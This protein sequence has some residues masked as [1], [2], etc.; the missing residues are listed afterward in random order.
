M[1]GLIGVAAKIRMMN[2]MLVTRGERLKGLGRSF[3]LN[4]KARTC[5]SDNFWLWPYWLCWSWSRK[6]CEKFYAYL[7]GHFCLE[8]GFRKQEEFIRGL[9]PWSGFIYVISGTLTTDNLVVEGIAGLTKELD[10]IVWSECFKFSP[11][12]FADKTKSSKEV[13]IVQSPQDAHPYSIQVLAAC[14]SLN[15]FEEELV[16]DPLEK[17]CL[18]WI[19]WNLS[20]S[21]LIIDWMLI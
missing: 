4:L 15:R 6:I 14:H 21:R 16:G 13:E 2:I 12:D 19:D 20:R 17:A 5:L 1:D 7:R 3:N 18:S 8:R 9:S 10:T 11:G